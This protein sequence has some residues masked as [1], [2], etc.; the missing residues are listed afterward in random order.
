MTRYHSRVYEPLMT[1][2][3]WVALSI[4]ALVGGGL[5]CLVI[6]LIGR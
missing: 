4:G 2:H 5:A 1:P 6:W 3:E